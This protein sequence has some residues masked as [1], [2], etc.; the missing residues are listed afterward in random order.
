MRRARPRAGGAAS[1][2]IGDAHR[3]RPDRA[4]ARFSGC[5]RPGLAAASARA[6]GRIRAAVHRS[7]Q[8]ARAA[9]AL[10]LARAGAC[11]LRGP[12]GSEPPASRHVRV[13]DRPDAG[14]GPRHAARR[15]R[16]RPLDS[17]QAA[18]HLRGSDPHLPGVRI[19]Y[20]RGATL[21]R[22]V[23][24]GRAAAVPRTRCSM[25]TNLASS[26]GGPCRRPRGARAHTRRTPSDR[27]LRGFRRLDAADHRARSSRS[28]PAG[29][30]HP[31]VFHQLPA[32]R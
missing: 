16:G 3:Q 6:R 13:S 17:A 30:V 7:V 1:D 19:R 12:R 15:S 2:C 9:L 23:R 32:R 28:R 20:R 29:T 5:G 10:R 27:R 25:G 14:R 22:G 26:G 31:R 24:A 21:Q 4:A 8:V 18:A 11:R